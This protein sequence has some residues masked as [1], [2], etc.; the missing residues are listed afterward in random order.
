MVFVWGANGPFMSTETK[1]AA[2][3]LT[4]AKIV[5]VDDE[6]YMR[7]VVRTMLLGIGVRDGARGGRRR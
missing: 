4:A 2:F 6:H 1:Q 7:K 5:V 3:R